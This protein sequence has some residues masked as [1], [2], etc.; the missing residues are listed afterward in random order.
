[1]FQYRRFAREFA[2]SEG[3]PIS[4]K[5]V[6]DTLH[7]RLIPF[8]FEDLLNAGCTAKNMKQL[9]GFDIKSIVLAFEPS[10]KQWLAANFTDDTVKK[11]GWDASLYRR[12]VANK[13]CEV[14]PEAVEKE[15]T[16][17]G[18][19]KSMSEARAVLPPEPNA[20]V[21][22]VVAKSKALNFNLI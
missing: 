14:V 9:E 11:A 12:F 10:G 22:N 8:S 7:N 20:S 1:M 2:Y 5:E 3:D 4:Q 18:R 13:T 19:P 17:V 15:V 6:Y 16:I 21:R